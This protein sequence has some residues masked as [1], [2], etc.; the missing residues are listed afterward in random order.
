MPPYTAAFASEQDALRSQESMGGTVVSFPEL[1]S[2]WGFTAYKPATG[3]QGSPPAVDNAVAGT[4][5]LEA[6]LAAAPAEC[7]YCGMDAA[8]SKSHVV[9]QWDNGEISHHDCWDCVFKYEKQQGRMLDVARVLAHPG[10]G[11]EWLAA[12]E[13][14]YLYDTASIAGSMPPYVAAFF[15]VEDAR[16]SQSELGGEVV[17]FGQLRAKLDSRQQ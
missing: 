15:T 1:L 3:T 17:D 4:P 14:A 2:R 16:A 12:T 9:V 13:A 10:D 7:P 8:K 11:P 5:E 6:A